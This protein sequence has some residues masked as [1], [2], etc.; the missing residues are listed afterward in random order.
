MLY[1]SKIAKAI[2][3]LFLLIHYQ[4]FSQKRLG[5][6]S[7]QGISSSTKKTRSMSAQEK[8]DFLPIVS[9]M[10]DFYSN[11]KNFITLDRQNLNL[12]STEKELQKSEDFMDG[13]M[14]SQSK[15]EGLD[16]I[17]SGVYDVDTRRLDLRVIDVANEK[18][19][20]TVERILDKNFF[21]IKDLHQQ[22]IIML[23]E[24]NAKCFDNSIP[25]VRVTKSRGSKA[26]E[27]LIAG[28]KD[29]KIRNEYIFEIFEVIEENINGKLLKRQSVIGKAIVIKVEDDNF[30]IVEIDKG[31][32]EIMTAI[33][34]K[35]KLFCRL[36]KNK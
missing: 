15:N 23:L 36:I 30:S 34:E 19:V 13:Y 28:G 24:L 1:C 6:M 32:E 10:V 4:A 7:V 5:V 8:S 35:K 27:A 33:N 20:G 11:D 29:Q 26:K 9:T 3:F 18:I 25:L 17:L 14:V 21:G 22:V 31:N 2:C 12:I 16:Y